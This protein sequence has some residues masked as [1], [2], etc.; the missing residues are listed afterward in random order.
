M[1]KLRVDSQ[2]IRATAA[3]IGTTVGAGIFA[4]PFV[5]SRSGVFSALVVLIGVALTS[6]LINL[7][8]ARVIIGTKGDHQLAGYAAIYLGTWG[9]F[10]AFFALV[11]G[12]YGALTV[13]VLQSGRLLGAI[14]PL[15]P[16]V[17]SLLF[18]VVFSGILVSGLGA[19]SRSETIFSGGVLVLILFLIVLALSRFRSVNISDIGWVGSSLGGRDV[20]ADLGVFLFALAGSSAIPEVEEI[21][22]QKRRR[23]PRVVVFSGGFVA[24]L[25]VLFSLAIVGACGLATT[26]A[27]L[28]GLGHVISGPISFLGSLVG[29]LAM[30]GAYLLVGYALCE[31]YFR[32]FRLPRRPSWAL[33]FVP[34][35]VLALLPQLD[36]WTIVSVTGMVS[37]TLSWLV[38]ILIYFRQRVTAR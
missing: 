29:V 22:R 25:Y 11:F 10:L 9:K 27:A 33:V 30:G 32:D 6:T 18:W 16:S 38:I 8:Y 7:L 20:L 14:L 1:S 37:I 4:L 13:Y 35:V 21:L 28:E 31:V 23:L 2:V 26:P 36:F 3:L 17:L 5:F 24:I 12:L 15:H 34:P 19:V